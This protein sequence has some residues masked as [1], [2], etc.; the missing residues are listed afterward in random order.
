MRV[1]DSREGYDL[2]APQYRKD[3][4]HLDSFDWEACRS[5]LVTQM[6]QRLAAKPAGIRFL[7]LGCGDGR[8]L[9]RLQRLCEQ[10]AWTDRVKLHG[11]DIS[12]GMLK[13][14]GKALGPEVKLERHDLVQARHTAEPFRFDVIVSFFVVVH[15]DRPVDFCRAAADLLVP[16]GRLVFNNIP[17]RDALVLESAGQ[18]FRIEYQHHEDETI[19]EA[20]DETGLELLE[21]HQTPW[22]TVFV[23]RRPD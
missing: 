3:H 13:Q 14:A 16:G 2:Y 20:L 15:I 1:L 8:V 11:W 17:Q 4:P 23:A 6:Q 12:E 19:R 7:D 22:S 21:Q 9:K 10:R 5:R 18:K